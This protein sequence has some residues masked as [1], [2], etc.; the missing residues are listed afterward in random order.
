MIGAK[1]LRIISDKVNGFIRDYGGTKYL[2][3]FGPEKYGVIFCKI[4]H[5]IRLKSGILYLDSQDYGKIKL[6]LDDD[7]LLEKTMII[8]NVVMLI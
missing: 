4:R 5:L 8:H 7:L 6:D 2:V 1:S 3:L